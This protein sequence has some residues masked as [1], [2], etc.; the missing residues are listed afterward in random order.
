M[1]KILSII[2]LSL[3]LGGNAFAL[4]YQEAMEKW[5]NNGGS[6]GDP[7]QNIILD[8]G[9]LYIVIRN[10]T[11]KTKVYHELFKK[12]KSA[13][14]FDITAKNYCKKN[15]IYNDYNQLD[16]IIFDDHTIY[17]FC[18]GPF[19][20]QEE[21]KNLN[22]SEDEMGELNTLWAL[23]VFDIDVDLYKTNKKTLKKFPFAK[24]VAKRIKAHNAKFKDSSFIFDIK[25][26]ALAKKEETKKIEMATMIDE[27]KAT[28]KLLG[29]EEETQQFSDCALKLYTQ[30][31][32]IAAKEKQT[33]VHTQV[34]T[35]TGTSSSGNNS[36]TIYDPVRDSNALIKKGQRMLSGA[37]TLGIDC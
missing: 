5:R 10:K 4:T 24:K 36:M 11:A 34:N 27:A 7:N 12:N 13:E 33:I 32:E 18:T 37:C 31:V 9:K 21:F 25:K 3:L 16:R 30:S 35:T 14:I 1:K 6:A 23:L 2:I 20:T 19:D 28:C 15:K 17:Y 22:L 26:R 8:S 29:M